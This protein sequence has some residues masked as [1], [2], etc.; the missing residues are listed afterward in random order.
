MQTAMSQA[1]STFLLKNFG[2]GTLKPFAHIHPRIH[3]NSSAGMP[4]MREAASSHRFASDKSKTHVILGPL[5]RPW[6]Y[7]GKQH[8]GSQ[9]LIS[10]VDRVSN[11]YS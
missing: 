8:K 10:L 1:T 3:A 2:S 5:A 11:A 9:E 6:R 4:D 7:Y